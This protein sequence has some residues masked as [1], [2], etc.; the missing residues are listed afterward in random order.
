[1]NREPATDDEDNSGQQKEIIENRQPACLDYV[2][3]IQNVMVDDALDQVEKSPPKEQRPSEQSARPKNVRDGVRAKK[4][5]EPNRSRNPRKRVKHAVPEHVDLHIRDGG[6]REA[7]GKHVVGL[8]ELVEE[9]AVHEPA[10]TD[11]KKDSSAC[12]RLGN[13]ARVHISYQSGRQRL[14]A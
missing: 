5:N 3:Q 7:R 1:M 2:M 9:D 6:F 14:S 4:E 13:D 12:K 11:S 8:E 10:K